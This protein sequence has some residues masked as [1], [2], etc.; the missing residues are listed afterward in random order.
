LADR[1]VAFAFQLG[2]ETRGAHLRM[3]CS[4]P[5][6]NIYDDPERDGWGLHNDAAPYQQSGL[7]L[8]SL[9]PVERG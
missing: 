5:W 1:L 8:G 3:L 6:R 7:A 9:L 4:R 2:A